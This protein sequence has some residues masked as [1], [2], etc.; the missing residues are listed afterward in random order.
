MVKWE[1][2]LTI[3]EA[4]LKQEQSNPQ[5]IKALL[6][7][8]HS[9][10]NGENMPTDILV[11]AQQAN[12]GWDAALDSWLGKEWQAIHA[13]YWAQWHQQK[14]SWHWTVDLIKKL[15]N[16]SWDSHVGSS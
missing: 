7:G 11:T 5:L 16:I 10:R 3:L 1:A 15:W 14:S 12:I 2:A 8:L 9:W 4:W 13:A 6:D